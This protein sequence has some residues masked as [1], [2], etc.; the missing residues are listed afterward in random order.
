MEPFAHESLLYHHNRFSVSRQWTIAQTFQKI[1]LDSKILF[2]SLRQFCGNLYVI[3]LKIQE[4]SREISQR[5][6]RT[7]STLPYV[8]PRRVLHAGRRGVF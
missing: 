4:F 5:R 6:L 3:S 2:V 7:R 1:F 8:W